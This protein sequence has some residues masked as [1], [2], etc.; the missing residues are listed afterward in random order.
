MSW[1]ASGTL[2]ATCGRDKSVWIWEA[3][4]GNEFECVSVLQGHSQDVKMP[5]PAVLL[6]AAE[7]MAILAL[8]GLSFGLASE[9]LILFARVQ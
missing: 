1:N 4:P 8:L 5:P 2:L 7:S 3:Q 9:S 6:L